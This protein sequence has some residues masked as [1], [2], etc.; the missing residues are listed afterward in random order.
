MLGGADASRY[1][2]GAALNTDDRLPLEFSAPRALYRDTRVQNWKLLKQFKT[3]ELPDLTPDSRKA[4]DTAQAR[5]TI[6]IVYLGRQ[7]LPD[8]LAHFQRALE[9]DPTLS[10]AAIQAGRVSLRLGRPTE[11]L[12]FGRQV[13]A[14]EPQSA[15]ALLVAGLASLALKAPAEATA[16]LQQAAALEPQNEEI[17]Q[18]LAKAQ[19]KP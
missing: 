18:A 4:V 3:A 14:R 7:V 17:R 12:G 10:R 9:L 6:G 11:A 15:E 1:A 13:L 19:T 16:F 5:Y 2:E 8:A